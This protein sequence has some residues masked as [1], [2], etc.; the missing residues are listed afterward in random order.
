MLHSPFAY[1]SSATP[2]ISP[3]HISII[4]L[5][6]PLSLST[7]MGRL[8][9]MLVVPAG[10]GPEAEDCS[11]MVLSGFGLGGGQGRRTN[12]NSCRA[13]VAHCNVPS[14]PAMCILTSYQRQ[15]QVW[16]WYQKQPLLLGRGLPRPAEGIASAH[17]PGMLL[18][19]ISHR[20][21]L[22]RNTLAVANCDEHV[23]P[24]NCPDFEFEPLLTSTVVCGLG[25]V[26]C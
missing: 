11:R 2:A 23:T 4:K 22:T 15:S 12:E 5:S 17:D 8:W 21:H 19:N 25:H 7:E 9:G 18:S 3:F 14:L 20:S 10:L 13:G 24:C 16:R 6:W 26:I 1:N